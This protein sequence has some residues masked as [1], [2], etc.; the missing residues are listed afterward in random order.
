ME[1]FGWGLS[2][3]T[4]YSLQTGTIINAKIRLKYIPSITTAL[5]FTVSWSK[6][7]I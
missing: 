2:E 4:R 3:L 5:K 6:F 1:G 7:G